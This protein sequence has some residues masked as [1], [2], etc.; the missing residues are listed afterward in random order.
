MADQTAENMNFRIINVNNNNTDNNAGLDNAGTA[1]HNTTP[2]INMLV[3][4]NYRDGATASSSSIPPRL[5]D[6]RPPPQNYQPIQFHEVPV[7]AGA[8]ATTRALFAAINQTNYLIFSQGESLRVLED[9][10]RAPRR[11]RR[12]QSP[13]PRQV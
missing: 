11:H 9:A 7:P 8:D 3:P 6:D 12:P 1:G 4:S 2:T 5:E 10:C 13:P